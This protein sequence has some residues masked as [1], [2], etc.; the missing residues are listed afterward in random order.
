MAFSSWFARLRSSSKPIYS[1][2]R[3]SI[4]NKHSR[5]ITILNEAV[6]SDQRQSPRILS[7]ANSLLP[8]ALAVSAGSLALQSQQNLSLCDSPNLDQ[9]YVISSAVIRN[10]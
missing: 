9:T 5:S 4:F 6:S 10:K 3:N 7:W 2:L 1:S 8:M